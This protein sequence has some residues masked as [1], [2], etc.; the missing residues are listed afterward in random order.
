MGLVKISK[1][2]ITIDESEARK[3]AEDLRDK[4][5]QIVIDEIIR[6]TNKI[7]GKP[8]LRF[9]RIENKEFEIEKRYSKKDYWGISIVDHLL[10][11]IPPE[12]MQETTRKDT[13]NFLLIH[14]NI[15]TWDLTKNYVGKEIRK[16]NTGRIDVGCFGIL[17]ERKRDI[18]KV[19][20]WWSILIY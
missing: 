3:I 12:V 2:L 11:K 18:C 13:Q 14:Y 20:V 10:F 1:D 4:L 17:D 6:R 16:F 5:N 7:P 8:G 15:D 19:T 9:L